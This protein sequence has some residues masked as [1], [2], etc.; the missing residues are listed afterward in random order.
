MDEVELDKREL[1]HGYRPDDSY[2]PSAMEGNGKYQEEFTW[3]Y[4][5]VPPG[6][7]NEQYYN[8]AGPG[9]AL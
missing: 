9:P 7:I 4:K 8:Y 1:L 5:D 3:K 2:N 6:G